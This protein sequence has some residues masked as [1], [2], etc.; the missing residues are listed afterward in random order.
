MYY[1]LCM[2]SQVIAHFTL[3]RKTVHIRIQTLMLSELIWLSDTV[4][5]LY[6]LQSCHELGLFSSS[7]SLSPASFMHPI[8]LFVIV[9]SVLAD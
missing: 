8:H 5:L 3:Q 2:Y 4:L 6:R 7:F 9:I 1:V